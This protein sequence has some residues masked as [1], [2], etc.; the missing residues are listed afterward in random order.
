MMIENKMGGWVGLLL[1]V[2][3][4][5]AVYECLGAHACGKNPTFFK[6]EGL[7]HPLSEGRRCICLHDH[8]CAS[9]PA[10]GK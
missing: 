1:K 5:K 3:V 4:N 8:L 6:S 7:R 2:I 9:H 10:R